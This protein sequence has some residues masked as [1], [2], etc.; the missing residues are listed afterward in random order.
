MKEARTSQCSA[1]AGTSKRRRPR[2]KERRMRTT[3]SKKIVHDK[4]AVAEWSENIEMYIVNLMPAPNEI[5]LCTML[6]DWGGFICHWNKPFSFTKLYMQIN[7]RI[8]RKMVSCSPFRWLDV[9]YVVCV[10]YLLHALHYVSSTDVCRLST[11]SW[12][13]GI[14]KTTNATTMCE[15]GSIV[16]YI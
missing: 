15:F 1:G 9:T 12:A 3:E 7:E 2:K 11:A 4:Q 6:C 10:R 16:L 8:Y 14:K 13:Q 5:V